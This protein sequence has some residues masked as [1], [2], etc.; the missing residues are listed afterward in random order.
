MKRLAIAFAAIF[1]LTGPAAIAAGRGKGHD[2]YDGDGPPGLANKSYGLSPG[3]AKKMWR[4][5]ERLPN[6]YIG[7]KYF[8]EE[9]RAYHLAP[10]RRGHRWVVIDGDAY[11]VEVA[12]GLVVETVFGVVAV[13]YGP[14]A[15]PPVVV[16]EP[17]DRWRQRYAHTYTVEEDPYYRDC[18]RSVNPAGVIGGALI[19]GLLG[20]ALGHGGGRTGATVAGVVVGGAVGA[21]LTSHLSCEDR[22]YAYKTYVNGFNAGRS[23]AKYEWRNPNNGNY[24]E[25]Q[26]R[27][28]YKDPDGFRC[29]NY[30]QRIYVTGRP[31]TAS[32]RACQQPD[33]SWAIMS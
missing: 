21:A 31:E 11:L 7:P 1:I 16:V 29:A 4:R 27:D 10:P 9:P 26:V 3:Q 33:G 13:N 15:P 22:G 32:G 30:T 5:G 6:V 17:E 18:H 19:G 8:V 14:P 2:D 25:F 20:N 24:G 12:T 28:Y 23:N